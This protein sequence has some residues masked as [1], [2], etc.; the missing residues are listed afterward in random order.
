MVDETIMLGKTRG[1]YNTLLTVLTSPVLSIDFISTRK[2]IHPYDRIKNP[3]CSK[4]KYDILF[5]V[6]TI[7]NYKKSL[8]IPKR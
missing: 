7:L 8:K 5:L 6:S 3:E 1:T 4:K 2:S